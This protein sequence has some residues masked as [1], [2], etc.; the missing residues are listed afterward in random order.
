[1]ISNHY[2]GP[3]RDDLKPLQKY[4]FC[5]LTLLTFYVNATLSLSPS[6]FLLC[7]TS[8]IFM[9]VKDGLSYQHD[10]VLHDELST[11]ARCRI[12]RSVTDTFVYNPHYRE[13]IVTDIPLGYIPPSR[14]KDRKYY[15]K[16]TFSRK[17]TYV[18]EIWGK[19]SMC[20]SVGI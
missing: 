1:M 15:T 10:N 12:I 14:T 13:S 8:I 6:T 18:R 9:N 4:Q 16:Q 2:F 17:F 7:I 20:T 19:I 5:I 11:K 3:V